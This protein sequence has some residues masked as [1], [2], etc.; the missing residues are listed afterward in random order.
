MDPTIFSRWFVRTSGRSLDMSRWPKHA[1]FMWACLQLNM[2]A[3]QVSSRHIPGDGNLVFHVSDST[4]GPFTMHSN[5]ASWGGGDLLA[6]VRS[7]YP[8]GITRR[9]ANL[10]DGLESAGAVG[11]LLEGI[12]D[13]KRAVREACS[14]SRVQ[15]R[16]KKD[17]AVNWTTFSEQY[18]AN[19]PVRFQVKLKDTL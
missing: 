4:Q 16:I 5:G 19:K 11:P 13:M 2:A 17:G 15:A 6:F 7:W 14:N 8:R 1:L 3:A 10:P 18:I 12:A 9:S